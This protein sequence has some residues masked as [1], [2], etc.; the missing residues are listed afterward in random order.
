MQHTYKRVFLIVMD[1]V[2]IGEAPDAELYNDKGAD[3]LGH[4]AEHLGGLHLPN[5]AKLGLG[6]IREIKGVPKTDKPLAFYTKMKEASAGK[7]TMTG[8]WELMGLK[9]D[10]PFQVFPDG[11]PEELIEELEKRTGRKVLGNK[12]ASGTAIIE[13]LGKEHMKTGAII[14][15]TSADSVL[16]IAAHEKVIPLNELYQICQ[17][18]RELTLDEKYMVGRVIAR[19]F[20]GEPGNFE[21]TANRHDYA[22]K[23]FGR[24]VMNELKD[25]GFDVIALGKISDIYDGEGITDAIRTKSNM[26]GMD[27]LIQTFDR[28][29][30]GLSFLNLVDFDAKFGHRRDPE[31]YGQALEEFDA[32]LP[33]V[34]EKMKEEDLLIITADHG[35]DPLHH[36]TDHTREY[37]PLLVYNS[38]YTK[39]K[40]LPIR[41]TFADVGATIA[42]N[43]GVQMPNYG[44]SFLTEL[45]Q[46]D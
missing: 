2:G 21:R 33:E 36:G 1:S 44:T 45:K 13:E 14:V 10:S 37:V 43:F 17:I 22:L 24:T 30:T 12:P 16:Q 32:R 35:N 15:Y 18:A 3:T 27:K 42:E 29:F 4:I 9:I 46:G 23:P 40:E 41:E 25:G 28:D 34:F 26:D 6:N 20:V 19:P 5:L 8:H 39:G 31:G 38:T 7:D 11:F